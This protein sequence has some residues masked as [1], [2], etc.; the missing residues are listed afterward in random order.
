MNEVAEYVTNTLGKLFTLRTETC[1]S[2]SENGAFEMFAYWHIYDGDHKVCE[3]SYECSFVREDAVRMDHPVG[4]FYVRSKVRD[5]YSW[6]WSHKY[7]DD[8]PERVVDCVI[9]HAAELRL[10]RGDDRCIR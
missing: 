9:Q 10:R 1:H 4:W 7:T 5:Q 2:T 6:P 3:M 8:Q